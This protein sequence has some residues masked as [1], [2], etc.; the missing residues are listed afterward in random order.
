VSAYSPGKVDSGEF[1]I[2]ILV[3]PQHMQKGKKLPRASALT[4]AERNGLSTF[5]DYLAESQNIRAVAKNLVE[6]AL[7]SNK[8]AGVFGVLLL[9]VAEVREYR[10][11]DDSSSSYCVYDTALADNPSHAEIFQ[12][13]AGVDESLKENRRQ[14]LFKLVRTKF[15]PVDEFRGG[16]LAPR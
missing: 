15:I 9:P 5:R 4:D 2:R 6:R 13:V 8:E 7:V 10:C 14:G 16:L 12:R 11:S 1:L 3:A